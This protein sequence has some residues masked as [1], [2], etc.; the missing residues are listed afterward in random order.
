M[1]FIV[2]FAL[3]STS[4]HEGLVNALRKYADRDY[5]HGRFFYRRTNYGMRMEERR[6]L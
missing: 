5:I 4:H 3:L 6:G 1:K 2:D